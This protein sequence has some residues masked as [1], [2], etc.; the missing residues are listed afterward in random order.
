MKDK[1]L[2]KIYYDPKQ[3][4]SYSSPQVLY[5]TLKKQGKKISLSQ[6]KKWLSTQ[7][8]YTFHRDARRPY[9]RNKVIVYGLDDQWDADLIDMIPNSKANKGYQYILL[10]IDIF[11]RYV[12]LEPLKSKKASDV[13]EALKLIFKKRKPY[14]LRTDKGSEF[15]SKQTARFLKENDIVHFV[16]HNSTKA[17]FAERC[18][19]TIKKKIVKYFSK[20]QKHEYVSQLQNFAYSY[21]HTPHRSIG[22]TPAEVNLKNETKLWK[23][24]YF[25]IKIKKKKKSKFKFKVGD[26]VLVSYDKTQTQFHKDY[27]YSWSGEVHTITDRYRRDNIPIY[28]LKGYDNIPIKGTFYQSEIQR[29]IHNPKKPFLVEKVLKKKGQKVYVHWMNWPSRYD[30]WISK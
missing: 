11:S 25:N 1:E 10:V 14:Y 13:I 16:T 22:M 23:Q 15:I 21:N 29:I 20:T 28:K 9:K 18:I 8:T 27:D 12:F 6:I 3:P 7:D 4:A 24:Q 30:S 17:N 19:R 26:T 2:E 5:K